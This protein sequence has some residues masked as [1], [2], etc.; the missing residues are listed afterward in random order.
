M[1]ITHK[2]INLLTQK[3][4][5]A[6]TERLPVSATEFITPDQIVESLDTQI[7]GGDVAFSPT[8]AIEGKYI[9]NSGT[10]VTQSGWSISSPFVLKK[11]ETIT[12]HT[13][14][15]G[16]CIIART[17]MSGSSY[18][19]LV[20]APS[21]TTGNN[22]YSYLAEK[23]TII[24]LGGKTGLNDVYCTLGVYSITSHIED[25]EVQADE[26]NSRVLNN[27]F[28]GENNDYV[29]T[30][31]YGVLPGKKYRI[32]LKNPNWD[33]SGVTVTGAYRF[34]VASLYNDQSTTLFYVAIGDSV[35]PYYDITIPVNCDYIQIGGRATKGTVVYFLVNF[36]DEI[37][38]IEAEIGDIQT[39]LASI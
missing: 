32:Y 11:G 25:V 28:I 26:I 33:M 12:I 13:Q 2:D 22:P 17:D 27:R 10:L 1:A 7:N 20:L 3:A 31:I 23:D 29:S 16:C 39:I 37:S 14:G 35:Q 38:T 34:S 6:G 15:S 8:W 21:G 18:T 9:G 4:T 24:A 30:K 5:I 36:E 19:P